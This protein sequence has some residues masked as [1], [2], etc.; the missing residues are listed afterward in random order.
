MVKKG[1]SRFALWPRYFDAR[2][3]RA[4]GRRVPQAMAVKDPDAPWIEAAARKAGFDA[5]LEE[6]ARDPY[7]PH[8]KAGR[9]LVAK[10]GGKETMLR[11]VAERMGHKEG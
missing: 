1:D 4:E 10:K 9:V 6:A 8:R 5:E 3:S 7:A 11:Q 2:L